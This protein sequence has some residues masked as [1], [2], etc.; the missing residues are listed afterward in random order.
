MMGGRRERLSFVRELRAF[1]EEVLGLE[2]DGSFRR[3]V[4]KHRTANWLYVVHGDRLVSALPG[5]E[6]YRFAW[7]LARM[8][9][10]ERYHRS[11][12]RHT[13]LYSA[14][15]HGGSQCPITPSLL[16]A[17]RARQG[18]VVLHEA[19]HST[20]RIQGVRLPYAL[21]E[22]TGRVVGVM[23]MLLF[24]ERRRD[25]ELIAEARRQEKD[26]SALARFV[27]RAHGE[28]TRFY[29]QRATVRGTPRTRRALFAEI[30]ARANALR[31][32]MESEWEREELGREINNAFVF[33]YYD[34]TRF[35]PLALKVYRT[36]GS[37]VR[38]MRLYK[39]AG[40]TGAMAQLKR[41]VVT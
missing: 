13:Y 12:G 34:Y 25:R 22:A 7:D 19:W 33:R 36:A 9:R 10:W 29:E 1:G 39:R 11:R 35:Y 14:E 15:A 28:L 3:S 23:G 32:R 26:W 21:E 16:E 5:K 8:R 17:A 24:A 20:L 4:S 38:A 18:Y 37:L 40:Q 41:F 30:G 27:N 2:F 31:T 6:I